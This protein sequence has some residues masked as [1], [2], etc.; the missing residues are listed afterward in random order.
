M[1]RTCGMEGKCPGAYRV[2]VKDLRENLM[3]RWED[4]IKMDLQQ[5]G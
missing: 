2:L 1:G 4:I 3:C 5:V